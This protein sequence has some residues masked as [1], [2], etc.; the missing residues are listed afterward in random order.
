M[1][2][3]TLWDHSIAS[4]FSILSIQYVIVFDDTFL[5]N[6]FVLLMNM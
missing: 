6:S 4:Y 1:Q 3:V 2:S 5:I